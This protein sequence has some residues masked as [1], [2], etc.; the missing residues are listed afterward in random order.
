MRKF[1]LFVMFLLLPVTLN[2]FSPY[3]I[4]DG[5]VN[6]VAAGA[7]F[8]WGIMFISSLFIGRAFCSYVCP[9]GG[10]QMIL[11]RMINK[12]LK[13]VKGLKYLKN[14]L[15]AVWIGIIVILL[16]K[17]KGFERIDFFYLTEKFVSVDGWIKLLGYYVVI[18]GI[19]ILPVILGKRATCRYL[20]P[21]S[22]LNIAGTKVKDCINI[23]SLRL[24]C[25]MDKCKSCG[26]CN[27]VCPMTIDVMKNVQSGNIEHSECILCGECSKICKAQVIKRVY[28]KKSTKSKSVEKDQGTSF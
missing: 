6:R 9:Y 10:L 2:Y 15:G 3:L 25:K 5:I 7:F 4:I 27:K 26:Q 19:L 13:R 17:S 12:P 1:C 23:P 21:M 20:C 18:T 14:I 22:I 28:N 16:I 8:I 11:D 24:S